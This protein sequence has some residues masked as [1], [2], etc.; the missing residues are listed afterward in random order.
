MLLVSLPGLVACSEGGDKP[1]VEALTYRSGLP[2]H[3]HVA[4]RGHEGSLRLEQV[5]YASVDGQR[6]PA[7]FAV[8]TDREPLGCLMYQGDLG[9]TKEGFPD[10]RSGA[11]AL[12]LATFTI[13]P[14][15][16]GARGSRAQALRAVKRPETL[17]EMVLDT[18]VHLRMGLDYRQRRPECRENVGYIGTA[19]G[20]AVGCCSLLRTGESTR[21]C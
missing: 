10:L 20:G 13:D 15:H 17:L 12:R 1:P 8:P 19:F 16:A 5:T 2:L 9:Q 6:V 4:D 11:A 7:L 18:V 3:V 21:S 14:R